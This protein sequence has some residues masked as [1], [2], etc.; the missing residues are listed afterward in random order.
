MHKRYYWLN[1]IPFILPFLVF[2]WMFPFFG[3][4]T[5]GNDYP[6]YSPQAQ[7]LLHF[8][9]LHGTFPLY[10]SGFAGGASAAALTLGGIYHPLAHLA[11]L[12]PDYWHGALLHC[13]TALRLFSLG[14]LHF[15]FF[16]LCLRFGFRPVL[17]LIIS[18]LPVYN[19]R[20][21]DMFR[22]G[23]ALENYIGFMLLCAALSQHYLKP[24]LISR[25]GIVISTYLLVT[26]GHPQIC[27]LGLC[28]AVLITVAL[29]SA[30]REILSAASCP[31]KAFR[32]Y[33]DA[34]LCTLVGLLASAQ[35]ILPFY[36]EFLLDNA[37][38]V[39]APYGSSLAYPFS[40]R[41]LIASFV[42]PFE[43]DVH[44]NFGGHPFF[45]FA[46]LGPV[47]LLL[48]RRE[49][50]LGILF[51]YLVGILLVLISI[52]ADTAVHYFFWAHLPLFRGMRTPG[53]ATLA[54]P[55]IAF[56]LAAW[57]FK[58][59]RSKRVEPL[60]MA[61]L[62][63][64]TAVLSLG[65][66]FWFLSLSQN[67]RALFGAF[68]P[69][70]ILSLSQD[71]LCWLLIL[72]LSVLLAL[73][74]SCL[75]TTRRSLFQ[76][77]AFISLVLCSVLFLRYG[78][79]IAVAGP[80]YHLAELEQ[81]FRLAARGHYYGGY[82]MS[83]QMAS[84]ATALGRLDERLAFLASNRGAM[85]AEKSASKGDSQQNKGGA[86][87]LEW[88]NFNQMV[89]AVESSLARWLVFTEP[90]SC[91]WKASVDG[92]SVDIERVNDTQ[93]A[94]RVPLGNHRVAFW[95]QSTATV[96]GSAVSYLVFAV[97]GLAGI[98]QSGLRCRPFFYAFAL[99]VPL[100]LLYWRLQSFYG[101]E[102]LGT[103]YH[104]TAGAIEDEVDKSP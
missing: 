68:S 75:L 4:L 26:G 33:T 46:A 84:R 41:D 89:F 64:F 35:Y 38:R 36:F 88:N 96:V 5:L 103:V 86:V 79:W 27:F 61:T 93:M 73:S 21:L 60:F 69:A 48:L 29:P 101:G 39:N 28:S 83:S 97:I 9:R 81:R 104:W 15:V 20:M 14:I 13:N 82:G 78:T 77:L 71:W 44:G 12:L 87:R 49:L 85:S 76:W 94:V 55:F 37:Q 6:L 23:A 95:Y 70:R 18:S 66:A 11:A 31:S 3:P 42:S 45:V 50:P 22:Y 99:L 62:L 10:V 17:C 30:L 53:R 34:L 47:V 25:L 24:S 74:L 58:E 57:L 8:S 56:V 52:G 65:G 32:F 16:R 40:W 43:A 90:F 98:Y 59:S 2:Y 72:Q 92:Q 91:R 1:A 7:V 100:G 51:L 67:S 63:L 80:Q 19:L 54:V 102:N